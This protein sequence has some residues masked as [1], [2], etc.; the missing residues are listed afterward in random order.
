MNRY[1]RGWWSWRER[2]RASVSAIACITAA[3]W[4]TG[5]PQEA[6]S[7]VSRGGSGDPAEEAQAL[8]ARRQAA[9]GADFSQPGVGTG[10]C[11]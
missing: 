5:E 11:A 10:L 2:S 7:G 1:E 9:A 3:K 6:A 8:R 4:R